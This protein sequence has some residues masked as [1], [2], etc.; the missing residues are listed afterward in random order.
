[1]RR[2]PVVLI[3]RAELTPGRLADVRIAGDRVSEI[4]PGLAPL[5]G[6]DIVD[7]AGAAL[8]PGLHDHHLHLPALAA[9]LHSLRCGP[10]EVRTAD[11]LAARLVAADHA[12]DPDDAWLRG[13]GYHESVAG[14]IGRD[15][16]DAHVSRRP[17]RLQHRSGRLWVLNSRALGMLDDGAADSP[18]E[19]IAGRPTGRLYDGDDWLRRRLRGE[20]PDLATASAFL[21]RRGVTG[22]TDATP[23][24]DPDRLA[25]LRDAR[26]RGGIRQRVLVMGD[27]SLSA[28]AST[29]PRLRVGPLK[30]HLHETALPGFDDLVAA[31]RASHADG[32]AVAVHCVTRAEL[33]FTLAALRE[34]GPGRGDRIEHASVAPPDTLPL[35]RALGLTVVTQPHFILERGDAYLS[36]VDAE[37]RAWLYRLRSFLDAGIRLAA[38]SDAPFGD[39]DPWR[40]MQ[41]AVD[42]RTA[43]GAICGP[44]EAL[45]P[46]QALALY[47]GD[48]LDPGGAP[49][50]IVAGAP[51]DLCLLDRPW[52]AVR[53]NLG[54]AR[55]RITWSGGRVI[56]DAAAAGP[57]MS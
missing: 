49:R 22:I 38:G 20:W 25:R 44:D 19:R 52:P 40:A 27:A 3:R 57:A 53:G 11:E 56:W 37:D 51:A 21:A 23:G 55:V 13:Y 42:R 9:A 1:M 26:D 41:A 16:L 2:A 48:A 28:A 46:E 7:A 35:L 54:D 50:R 12:P 8:L 32:R 24:N 47:C 6:D 30:I 4:G 14:D 10:P 43:S 5:P 34:A 15:W 33:H 45:T 18:L 29:D 36:D 31:M 39:A 17:A